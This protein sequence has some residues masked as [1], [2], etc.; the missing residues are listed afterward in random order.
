MIRMVSLEQVRLVVLARQWHVYSIYPILAFY[1]N[2]MMYVSQVSAALT[3]WNM[4]CSKDDV[5]F[6]D[7]SSSK[8]LLYPP[9]N[10]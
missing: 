3:D 10:G 6:P 4:V 5:T 9:N 8:H 2:G 7:S 1:R